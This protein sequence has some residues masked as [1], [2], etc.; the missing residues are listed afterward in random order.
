MLG[1]PGLFVCLLQ[2]TNFF[3]AWGRREGGG[4]VK[5]KLL[6]CGLLA[7]ISTQADNYNLMVFTVIKVKIMVFRLI[8]EEPATQA[9]QKKIIQ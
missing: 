9:A 2:L 3:F 8:F 5:K 4:G 7:A 6:G 1:L